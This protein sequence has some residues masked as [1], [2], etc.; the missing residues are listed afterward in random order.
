MAAVTPSSV[1]E[2]SVGSTT[3]LIAVFANTLDTADTWTTGLTDIVHIIPTQADASGVQ[4]A[5]GAGV[6]WVSATGIVT[7]HLAEDNTAV[8]LLVLR[9]TAH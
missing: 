4:A 9:G 2:I 8:R 5:T 1:R 6:S 3:G 7:F